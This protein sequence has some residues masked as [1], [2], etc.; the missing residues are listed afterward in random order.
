M[1][2]WDTTATHALAVALARVKPEVIRMEE[3]G[4][5]AW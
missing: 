3:D 1:V 2:P 5:P 4:R